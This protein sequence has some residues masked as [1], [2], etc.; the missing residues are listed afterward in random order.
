MERDCKDTIIFFE[1]V[2]EYFIGILHFQCEGIRDLV[3]IVY[4]RECA[5]EVLFY[6]LS[7][8]TWK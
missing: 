2:K 8:N 1:D 4:A 3:C 6:N 5:H 7:E